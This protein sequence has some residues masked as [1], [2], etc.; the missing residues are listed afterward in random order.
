MCSNKYISNKH[1]FLD[2]L[3][4][5]YLQLKFFLKTL[6]LHKSRVN[7]LIDPYIPWQKYQ[8]TIIWWLHP[9]IIMFWISTP[10]KTTNI[11]PHL[12]DH[13][14]III[15]LLVVSILCPLLQLISQKLRHN[16][17]DFLYPFFIAQHQIDQPFLPIVM[18]NSLQIYHHYILHNALILMCH[19]LKQLRY[20]VHNI[21][22]IVVYQVVKY[23][24]HVLLLKPIL[25]LI[26]S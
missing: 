23:N 7:I 25:I 10:L 12:F 6:I 26:T 11:L 14:C 21:L 1:L 16:R 20:R 24:C 3:L 18:L 5:E 13:K 17:L 22:V 8:F 2:F 19:L 15:F 9:Q 4:Q